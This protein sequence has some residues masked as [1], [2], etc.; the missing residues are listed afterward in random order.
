MS[1]LETSGEDKNQGLAAVVVPMKGSRKIE[2]R[3]RGRSGRVSSWWGF[4]SPPWKKA[5]PNPDLPNHS[6]NCNH[7]AIQLVTENCSVLPIVCSTYERKRQRAGFEPSTNT[8]PWETQ[9]LPFSCHLTTEVL[10]LSVYHGLFI[11]Q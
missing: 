2:V 1:G 3:L 5:N 9:R 4:F 6:C 11:F 8:T 10:W 7:R